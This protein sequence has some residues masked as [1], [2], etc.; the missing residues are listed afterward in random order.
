MCSGPN[1]LFERE[2]APLVASAAARF[3][4]SLRPILS[5]VL[6]DEEKY[7][8]PTVAHAKIFRIFLFKT[9]VLPKQIVF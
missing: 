2:L 1:L 3:T 4:G 8:S 6:I 5:N 9:F 7:N